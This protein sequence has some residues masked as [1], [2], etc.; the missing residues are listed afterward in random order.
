MPT[1]EL[2]PVLARRIKKLAKEAGR[3]P[4]EILP[5]VLKEGLDYCEED[6]RLT[7]LAMTEAD[8]GQVCS[9]EALDQQVQ[10]AIAHVSKAK[11]A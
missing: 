7:K 1:M 6:V 9:R 3:T 2:D 10:A 11:A 4:E 8:A 5:F